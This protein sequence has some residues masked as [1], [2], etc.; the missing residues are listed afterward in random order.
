MRCAAVL[1]LFAGCRAVFGL[2]PPQLTDASTTDV[3][4]VDASIDAP[5]PAKVCAADNNLVACFDF[6]GSA[7]DQAPSPNA[8][9]V[10]NV[11]FSTE[12]VNGGAIV[13]D[14]ATRMT[15]QESINLD[16]PSVTIEAWVY[17]TTAPPA[18][19]RS[20]VFDVNG[21]YGMFIKDG[22]ALA[23]TTG[24]PFEGGTITLNQWTHVA[25]T[26]SSGQSFAYVNGVQV[27]AAVYSGSSLPT[28]PTDGG[29]I[30]GNNPDGNER[31]VGKLDVVRVYRV[32]RSADQICKDAGKM[33]C[34]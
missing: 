14:T 5:P 32:A 18:V 15:I 7:T 20:G 2:E 30:A 28:A 16:V 6:E 33:G 1:V 8:V 25:C 27:A 23:C 13:V 34:P 19:S 4:R 22:F 21:Q 12:G 29:E 31:F 9:T 24:T 17:M 3:P 10:S 11:S 26:A